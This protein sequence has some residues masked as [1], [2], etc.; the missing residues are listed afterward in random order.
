MKRIRCALSAVCLAVTVMLICLP[1]AWAQT[2][3]GDKAGQRLIWFTMMPGAEQYTGAVAVTHIINQHSTVKVIVRPYARVI[4]GQ[5]ALHAKAVDLGD[6][7]FANAYH[8]CY[9]IKSVVHPEVEEAWPE[10]RMVIGSVPLWWGWMTRPDTGIKKIQDLKGHTI[11][12]DIPGQGVKTAAAE[13]TLRVAGIEPG[14]DF[15][16]IGADNPPAAVK[17]L[18][19]KKVDAVFAP[20]RGN[21]ITEVSA[22]TRLVFLPFSPQMYAAMPPE[23]RMTQIFKELPAGYIKGMDQQQHVLA[24]MTLIVTRKDVSEEATYTVVKTIMEHARELDKVGSE[25]KEWG[26]KEFALPAEFPVPVH[27]GA[28]RYFKEAGM[29]TPANEARQ[30]ERLA[31]LPK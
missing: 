18:G 1:V 19:L 11:N 10:L 24:L 17:A 2:P 8:A 23:A 12:Y 26:V 13:A 5:A 29:W 16:H 7:T 9:G 28:I 30:T 15:K 27:P 3:A 20:F 31:K 4:A 6:T 22:T 25:F 21:M 14:K